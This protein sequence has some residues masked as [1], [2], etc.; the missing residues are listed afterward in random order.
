MDHCK[1]ET[2]L[3]G[4]MILEKKKDLLPAV[5]DHGWVLLWQCKVCGHY[6]ED[7]F[8]GRYDEREQLR[9]LAESDM[10]P[11]QERLDSSGGA[12]PPF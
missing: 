10:T 9:C 8:N 6:W 5:E 11:W 4:T 3:Y 12:N 7:S 1:P 2:I